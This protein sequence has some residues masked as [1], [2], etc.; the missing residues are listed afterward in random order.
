MYLLYI[1]QGMPSPSIY[2][3]TVYFASAVPDRRHFGSRLTASAGSL[4]F[5]MR[6]HLKL[7]PTI[8]GSPPILE[9]AYLT[10]K[11]APLLDL[12]SMLSC[13]AACNRFYSIL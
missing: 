8:A 1:D 10:T 2:P 5:K 6:I 4:S 11:H 9:N 3:N 13:A 7:N 12:L